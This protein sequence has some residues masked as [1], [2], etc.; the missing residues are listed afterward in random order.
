MAKSFA[1]AS[2]KPRA[3]IVSPNDKGRKSIKNGKVFLNDG[4]EFEIELF[5]PLTVSVL[6]DI[7]LNGQSIS[8]TGLVVKPGQRVYLDCFID[9]R[10]KFKFSTYEIEASLE[11][12]NATAN[13]GVLE[14]FFYKEDVITLDNW[15]RRFDR[16]IVEKYY[17][18]N[19]Y[20]WYLHTTNN[21]YTLYG[22]TIG[23]GTTTLTNGVNINPSIGT[24]TTSNAVYNSQSINSS[25]T[26]DLNV[27]YGG[28]TVNNL[29]TNSLET[30]RVEKGE[31][32]KQK[33][34]EVDME[35]EKNYISSTIIQILPE[36]RKPAEVIKEEKK[37]K[38]GFQLKSSFKFCPECGEI[39]VR[40]KT[41][42]IY[43]DDSTYMY[44]EK[45]YILQTY[46]DNLVNF[47]DRFKNKLI[48]IQKSSLTE[49]SIRAVVI[50]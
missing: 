43:T 19:P 48:I 2:T 30:G 49:D 7:K 17:P 3:W 28:T 25:Y 44:N 42:I 4:D 31:K 26:T 11:S 47:L 33:F 38:C 29:F 16:V 21:P 34:T 1:Q 9:D 45:R 23:T 37:C 13:N 20:P 35:F 46:R 24:I 22:T 10:K 50:D 6:A 15:Q 12:I 32:S 14:V 36:S 8:K 18:Y 5:N 41:E 40:T 27:S 39:L